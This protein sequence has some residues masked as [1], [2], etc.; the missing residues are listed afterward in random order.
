MPQQR[1]EL[2]GLDATIDGHR[3]PRDDKGMGIG[4]ALDPVGA[5]AIRFDPKFAPAAMI[6]IHPGDPT[7]ELVANDQQSFWRRQVEQFGDL[8]N[9]DVVLAQS[10]RLRL[11]RCHQR[12]RRGRRRTTLLGLP[13]FPASSQR[14]CLFEFGCEGPLPQ[15]VRK[16]A[17]HPALDFGKYLPE[18]TIGPRAFASAAIANG[19][20]P[21]MG[22]CGSARGSLRP[23][24]VA[25]ECRGRSKERGDDVVRWA[26]GRLGRAQYPFV[27]GR[28]EQRERKGRG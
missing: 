1:S 28:A 11:G 4:L 10:G 13:Q 25:D 5:P 27:P 16:F 19:A 23:A 22:R 14:C 15:P 20:E 9:G 24:G 21:Q 26:C 12:R 18:E 17:E 6:G 2:V 8:L 3:Q 7:N